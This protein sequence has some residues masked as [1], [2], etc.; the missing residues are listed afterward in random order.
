[1]LKNLVKKSL[2]GILRAFLS[3]LEAEI[4]IRL[5]IIKTGSESITSIVQLMEAPPINNKLSQIRIMSMP[6]LT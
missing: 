5:E 3:A 4:P 1:M 2:R 6:V